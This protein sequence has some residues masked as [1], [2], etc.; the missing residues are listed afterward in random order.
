MSLL[1]IENAR[2]LKGT[3]KISGSK[4]A[5]IP[6]I[7][8]SLLTDRVRLSNVPKIIDIVKLL[9]ILN[10]INVKTKWNKNNLYID[11]RNIVYK[12]LTIEECNQIRGS[13]YLIPV[14]LY[15]FDK[16]EIVLPG[17][18]KIGKRPID[19]HLDAISAFGYKYIIN[20]NYLKIK[21]D[22]RINNIDYSITKKSVG[23]SINTLVLALKAQY[24]VISNL[25][26]EPEGFAV[27][28]FLKMMGFSISLLN[29]KSVI[30]N[31]T[32]NYS[33]IKYK[34]IP[35]RIEAMTFTVMGLLC[36]NLKIKNIDLHHMKNPLTLLIKSKYDIKLLKNSIIAKKSNGRSFDI[37]TEEYPGFPTDLQAIFGVLL[38]YSYGSSVVNEVI[39][40]NRMQIY[41]N[42]IEL[43]SDITLIDNKAYIN[44]I[45]STETIDF[46]ANDLRHA[47]A[48]TILAL[49][50]GGNV[51]N[52]ELIERGYEKFFS[53]ITKLGAKFKIITK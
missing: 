29:N 45:I 51:D 22:R 35:D 37:T 1:S 30:K 34:I 44:G 3:V 47:A 11:S 39:F 5:A 42:L 7:C 12:P 14:F 43:G 4:N 53:K 13:Y 24:A 33:Y 25:N 48:L 16:C 20:D 41:N 28:E 2:E 23:A 32:R 6:I 38:N 10:Y 18:C 8:T 36:G 52:I 31:S 46:K 15:L 49:R 19:S 17:G 27:I 26:I 21:K 9:K 40:E 50:N